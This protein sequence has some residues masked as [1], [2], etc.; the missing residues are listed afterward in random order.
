MEIIRNFGI[1]PIL[2]LA[3]IINFLII[4]FLLKKFFYKPI[5]KA[6]EDRKKRIEE[7][8]KNVDLIEKKL[9]DVQKES[10]MI[11]DQAQ[12]NASSIISNAKDEAEMILTEA[13]LQAR[14]NLEEALVNARDQIEETKRQAQRQLQ[15]ETITLV[16]S[17]VR[18][19]LGKT[20]KVDQRRSLTAKAIG[21]IQKQ[22]Q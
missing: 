19:V 5:T 22:I 3:Q 2:L 6:L 10:T 1:Q 14:N 13:N 8:L 12:K 18:R 11:I 20:L 21:E 4:L 15:K 9:N 17:V 7:S 16:I